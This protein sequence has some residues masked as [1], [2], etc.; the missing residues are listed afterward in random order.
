MYECNSRYEALP[1]AEPGK[2]ISKNGLNMSQ[3]LQL[4]QFSIQGPC[5]PQYNYNGNYDPKWE[6]I[7]ES[8]NKISLGMTVSHFFAIKFVYI[9]LF[10][11]FKDGLLEVMK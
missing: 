9:F 8:C 10:K 11:N 5:F 1:K 3:I 2:V 6:K 7:T 4:I